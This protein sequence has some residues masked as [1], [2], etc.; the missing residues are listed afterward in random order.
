MKDYS[1]EY[2][3]EINSLLIGGIMALIMS[4]IMSFI[5]VSYNVFYVLCNGIVEHFES[6]FVNMW[7]RS[8]SLAFAFG[9]PTVFVVAPSVRKIVN[10][11]T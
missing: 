7:P 4:S 1:Y 10:I 9:L 6:N 11:I 2:S 8:F 5:S 3:Q